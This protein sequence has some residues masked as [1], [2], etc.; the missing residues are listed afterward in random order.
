M[1]KNVHDVHIA[2][3]CEDSADT[4]RESNF[5]G[6][7]CN[8]VHDNDGIFK[9]LQWATLLHVYQ[10]QYINIIYVYY[11]CAKNHGTKCIK[12]PLYTAVTI[13]S[14]TIEYIECIILIR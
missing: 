3:T 13:I 12:W 7:P 10:L 14:I 6:L 8:T 11:V 2:H 9:I 4:C 1:P 5:H